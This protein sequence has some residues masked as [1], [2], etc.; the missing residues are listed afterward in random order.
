MSIKVIGYCD[1]HDK[2]RGMDDVMLFDEAHQFVAESV[3][4][5]DEL[6]RY[7]TERGLYPSGKRG[8]SAGKCDPVYLYIDAI[9]G[10]FKHG[11]HGQ[12]IGLRR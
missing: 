1:A 4:A 8:A 10:D 11:E 2:R 6:R 12:Y 3:P 7:A 9:A 5:S